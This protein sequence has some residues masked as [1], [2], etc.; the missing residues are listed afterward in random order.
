MIPG[1]R[2]STANK[3]KSVYIASHIVV[4]S[5]LA[6]HVLTGCYTAGLSKTA[7]SGGGEPQQL[8]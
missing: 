5:L 6:I 4:P 8:G 2:G 1:K 7:L 3:K